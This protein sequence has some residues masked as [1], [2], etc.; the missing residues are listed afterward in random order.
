MHRLA[1]G[2]KQ[3]S[4]Q[5]LLKHRFR[6]RYFVSYDIVQLENIMQDLK[7]ERSCVEHSF[8]FQS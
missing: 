2:R 7:K 3:H 4:S 8:A 5:I 1:D 6:H